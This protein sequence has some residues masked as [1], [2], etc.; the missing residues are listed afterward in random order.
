MYTEAGAPH[1]KFKS[2]AKASKSVHSP[3]LPNDVPTWGRRVALGWTNYT[4]HMG[5]SC[6][7]AGNG[8]ETP[9]S[10]KRAGLFDLECLFPNHAASEGDVMSTLCRR[11]VILFFSAICVGELR[12][13]EGFKTYINASHSSA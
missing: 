10:K 1:R 4:T 5:T 11:A 2:S 8:D 12:C 6:E 7:E 9:D 13:P 3:V